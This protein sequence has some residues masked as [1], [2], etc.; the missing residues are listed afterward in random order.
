VSNSAA[1]RTVEQVYAEAFAESDA[2]DHA[3]DQSMQPRGFGLLLDLVAELGLE[4]GATAV[5]VGCRMA[6]FSIALA[7]RFGLN[8]HGIDP[9]TDHIDGARAALAELVTAEPDVA[10]RVQVDIG[11]A[12]QLD[13]PDDSVALIW[14][15]DVLEHVPDLRAVFGE[16]RRVLR[17]D[18]HAVIYQMMATDW[19]EPEEAER[20]WQPIGVYADS[21]DPRNFDAAITDSGLTIDQCIDLRGE[22]RE[23]D[24]EDG[25]GMTSRQLIHASRLIRGKSEF[26][27]RFGVDAYNA[28]LNNCLWGVYQMIGKLSPRIYVLSRTAAS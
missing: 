26:E 15:R 12:E 23:R 25:D 3:L 9:L 22:W 11:R 8:V 16:F 27:T 1:W 14:C 4:P 17:P 5:D 20:L 13:D 6:Y 2:F 19:L 24:E 21:V 7:R 10:A 28:V 18:G